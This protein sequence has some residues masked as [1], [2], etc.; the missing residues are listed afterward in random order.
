MPEAAR[1]MAARGITRLVVTDADMLTGIVTRSDLLKAFLAPDERILHQVRREVVVHALWDDRFGI[2]L[3]VQDGVVTLS[4]EVDRHSTAELA[5][6][7][8]AGVDGVVGVDNQLKWVYDDT[9]SAPNIQP[10]PEHRRR[11]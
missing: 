4:G 1:L 2:E 8:T 9:T 5:E 7:L 11:P 6:N 10:S 3:A